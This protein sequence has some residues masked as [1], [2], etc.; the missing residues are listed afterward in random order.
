MRQIVWQKN[1]KAFSIRPAKVCP[2]PGGIEVKISVMPD[3][4]CEKLRQLRPA[5][6]PNV[7]DL[8]QQAGHDISPWSRKADGTQAAMPASNGSYCYDWAFGSEREGV[9]LCVWHQSLEAV[10]ELI[11]YRENLRAL[12][13][14]LSNIAASDSRGTGERNRARPQASRAY[15]FDALVRLAFNHLLPIRFIIN[16]GSQADRN[17]LGEGSSHVGKRALDTEYW[18]VHEYD[19]ASGET[20]IIRGLKPARDVVDDIASNDDYQGP[21]DKR[22]LAAINVR[23]GQTEFRDKLLAAWGR[24]C[25]VTECQVVG[26]LEAAHITPHAEVSDFRTCNG[27]LL[28]A[29]IHT[30]YDL[31]L[32]SIDQHMRVH[33]VGELLGSEYRQ[34][35]GKR[36][37]RRPNRYADAPST[38]ALSKRH[39][40][41]LERIKSQA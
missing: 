39:T 23:R 25:V 2:P 40:A 5:R 36:I 16:D 31:G 17:K 8:L 10:G 11:E 18:Y 34:Y 35:D 13:D 14:E 30:L 24:R 7:I 37:E 15:K 3:L 21:C 28:R 19:E 1:V 38:E 6:K 27:L 22:Q 20:K 9:V 29:D 33:L 26:I 12:G 4:I 41:F 32:L